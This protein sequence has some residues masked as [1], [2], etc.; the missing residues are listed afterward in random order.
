MT[1]KNA[2]QNKCEDTLYNLKQLISNEYKR[3]KYLL[4]GDTLSE[5]EKEVYQV[6][7]SLKLLQIENERLKVEETP[8]SRAEVLGKDSEACGTGQVICSCLFNYLLS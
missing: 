3:H 2:K 1:F 7:E 5:A 4:E 8:D 6:N